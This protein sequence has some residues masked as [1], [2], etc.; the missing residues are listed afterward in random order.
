M[1]VERSSRQ[2][3]ISLCL[4]YIIICTTHKY[5]LYGEKERGMIWCLVFSGDIH[6]G[7]HHQ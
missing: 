2:I 7:G 5:T 3:K 1:S 4:F 6:L